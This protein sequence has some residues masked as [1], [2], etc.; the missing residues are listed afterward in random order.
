LYAIASCVFVA[1]GGWAFWGVNWSTSVQTQ[2]PG[3]ILNRI[4]AYE[5]AGS[6]A[7]V[8]VGQAASGPAAALFGARHVLVAG[9]GVAVAAAATLLAIPA[10]RG[11]SAAGGAGGRTVRRTARRTVRHG[12]KTR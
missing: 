10:V 3:E 9:G 11:L 7:M 5:V 6:I 1:G 8:P 12:L 4:H 2:V